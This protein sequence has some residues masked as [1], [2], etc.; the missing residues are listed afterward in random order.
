MSENTVIGE[1]AIPSLK[2]ATERIVQALSRNP[3]VRVRPKGD[4]RVEI[5][6]NI[7]RIMDWYDGRRIWIRK[8]DG[9]LILSE[10]S[11]TSKEDWL[12][13]GTSVSMGRV[14]VPLFALKKAGLDGIDLVVVA[15]DDRV[16][17]RADMKAFEKQLRMVF[18]M[19]GKLL[20]E[21]LPMDAV[22]DIITGR[23]SVRTVLAAAMRLCGLDEKGEGSPPSEDI[24][25][26]LSAVMAEE[27]IPPEPEPEPEILKVDISAETGE[28]DWVPEE[29]PSLFL[30]DPARPVVMRITGN[31]YQF[32]AH[33]MRGAFKN[34]AKP[35]P[36]SAGIVDRHTRNKNEL[37]LCGPLCT[38][39]E[40]RKADKMWLV[41]GLVFEAGVRS[42]GFLM[43]QTA[44]IRKIARA[45]QDKDRDRTD[46][47]L[48]HRAWSEGMCE[49]F[50]NP[51]EDLLP[52]E[53]EKARAICAAPDKFLAASFRE[54]K[55]VGGDPVRP[56]MMITGHH[57]EWVPESQIQ[58]PKKVES[59]T[60]ET[61][62]D[63]IVDAIETG[64]L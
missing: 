16:T 22:A 38:M 3:G 44:V 20:P 12:I 49:V 23:K 41:P 54:A 21:D 15:E 42:A 43:V 53:I 26:S 18:S 63:E 29:P 11:M 30:P 6:R 28:M 48:Y 27:P 8:G 60:E 31:P 1:D 57:L 47:I 58:E 64:T 32:Y 24:A 9:S 10:D 33:W 35:W 36:G 19:F 34:S 55:H 61:E 5:P 45:L 52:G 7:V 39:C 59:Y 4:G 62:L 40:R 13:G 25:F 2:E 37:A 56:P 17:A 51:P 46:I 14:R 50:V